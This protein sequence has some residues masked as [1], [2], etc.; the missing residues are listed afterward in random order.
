SKADILIYGN[1]ERAL[2]EVAH[3]FAKGAKAAEMDDVR[4]VA[5]MKA[6]VP[7]GYVEAHADDVESADEGAAR[8]EGD[9]VVRLPAFETVEKD[10]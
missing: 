8:V 1:A 3:R 6:A 10:S 9:V 4:G 2:V 5:L 7:D